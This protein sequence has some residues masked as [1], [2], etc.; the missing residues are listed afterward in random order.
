MFSILYG[1]HGYNGKSLLLNTIEEVLEFY[2]QTMDKSVMLDSGV[3]KSGGNHSTEL[4]QLENKRIG[5]L[6]DS[7]EGAVLND[8][9][10]K[11]VTSITDKISAR[12]IY[13]IQKE[14]VPVF[15]PFIC[16]NFVIKMNLQDQAMYD[17]LLI[18]PFDL[19]FTDY[20]TE[21]YHRQNDS[22]LAD[23]LR[24][25]KEGILKWLVDACIFYNNNQEMKIPQAMIDAKIAYNNLVNP[26]L[27]FRNEYFVVQEGEKIAR[28]DVIDMFQKYKQDNMLKIPPMEYKREL[29]KVFK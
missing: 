19:K 16:T 7:K 21:P 23:K 15:V 5:Q 8:A 1:P 11:Q 10:A 12:E 29:D 25:N 2:V 3:Q 28:N 26:Y 13:G 14:F 22:G 9:T 4:M 24:K 20:P 27:D 18:F 17:R 6:T